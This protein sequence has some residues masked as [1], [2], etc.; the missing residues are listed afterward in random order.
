MMLSGVGGGGGGGGIEAD[1]EA[2]VAIWSN[3]CGTANPPATGTKGNI[4]DDSFVEE[5]EESESVGSL[6]PLLTR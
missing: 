5:P 1:V 6:D 2:A 4:G 3:S